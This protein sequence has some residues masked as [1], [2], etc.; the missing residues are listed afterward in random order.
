MILTWHNSTIGP[1]IRLGLGEVYNNDAH[2]V[3]C[4]S[5]THFYGWMCDIGI[6]SASVSTIT[7]WILEV[8]GRWCSFFFL[9]RI[10]FFK[11]LDLF[12]RRRGLFF[13]VSFR[14]ITNIFR[15]FLQIEIDK[16]SWNVDNFAF[17]KVYV[18]ANIKGEPVRF[19]S[20]S[21]LSIM[22]LPS[23]GQSIANQIWRYWNDPAVQKPKWPFYLCV[24][25]YRQ[26]I[27]VW[28]NV[29]IIVYYSGQVLL[30]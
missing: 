2:R 10:L 12:L 16:S 3:I 23:T 9:Y 26:Q 21:S 14:I 15:Y 29:L 17:N 11:I 7:D 20:K 5:S 19:S 8:I 1:F 13:R 24:Q 30:R 6:D 27:Y 25:W 28:I 22:D 18:T 4:E